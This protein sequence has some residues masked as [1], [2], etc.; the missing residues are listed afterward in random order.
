LHGP[1]GSTEVDRVIW[2]SSAVVAAKAMQALPAPEAL[3]WADQASALQHTAIATVYTHSP[4]ATLET[5]MLAL[6]PG[7]GPNW[8]QFVFDRGQL[9][10]HEPRMAGVWAWVVSACEGERESITAAVMAQAQ[11]LWPASGLTHL[12][13]VVDKRAAYACRPGTH[14]P[15]QRITDGVWAAGDYTEGPY[16]STLEAATRSGVAAALAATSA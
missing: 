2:A 16:P 7:H 14:K 9:S 5:P 12:Q 8:A 3:A 6:R 11:G 10:P 15:A 13:T 1:Q 4:A